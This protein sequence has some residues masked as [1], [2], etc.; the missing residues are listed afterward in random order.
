ML[1]LQDADRDRGLA[2]FDSAFWRHVGHSIATLFRASWRAW[3]GALFAPAPDAGET[4]AYYRLLS[5]YASAFALTS[6]MALLTLGG[7]L[8]RKEMLSARL[9]DVLSELVLLSAALKR[10]QD[11]GR[12]AADLPLVAWCMEDGFAT[13]EARLDEVLRHL[14]NRP[15]AW[16]LRAATL[17]FGPRRRGPP[18]RLTVA[19]AE[20]LL[21]PSAARARLTP[22]LF[23]GRGE[24][25]IA[26]LER[27]F[28]LVV[29]TSPTRTR[30]REAGITNW[31]TGRDAGR[32]TADEAAQFEAMEDAVRKVI[33]VDDFASEELSPPKSRPN[34]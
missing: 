13:I 22:G 24:D 7:A 21:A 25:G 33:V 3:T 15:A 20:I 1:A 9:G 32:L 6:D 26:R 2:R 28:A 4:T 10:W 30:L 17:P 11:E 29:A 8:K 16:L 12:Q 18:D 27:A 34:A 14:P 23:L 5:R 19:C 31:R